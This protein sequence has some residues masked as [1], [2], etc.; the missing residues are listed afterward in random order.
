M[1]SPSTGPLTLWQ[2]C[3]TLVNTLH[4]NKQLLQ[5]KGASCLINCAWHLRHKRAKSRGT[6]AAFL[7][8][9][10]WAFPFPSVRIDASAIHVLNVLL[11]QNISFYHRENAVWK[12]IIFR[13]V[14]LTDPR[15]SVCITAV[16]LQ[17]TRWGAEPWRGYKGGG[18]PHLLV[19]QPS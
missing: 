11:M 1:K 9:P 19:A 10:Q 6:G 3:L 18:L 4:H 15:G 2:S 5:S 16:R 8:A 7:W 17:Q 13:R 14:P 12:R